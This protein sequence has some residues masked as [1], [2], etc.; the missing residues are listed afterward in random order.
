MIQKIDK[1]GNT[2]T[3][4]GRVIV[5]DKYANIKKVNKI[6]WG[7]ITGT[8]TDQTDL[9]TYLSTNYYPLTSNP[10]GYLTSSSLPISGTVNY[11]P[12]FTGTNSLGSS[13]ITENSV[14]QVI[15]NDSG[16]NVLSG[17]TKLSVQ[18]GQSQIDFVLGNPTLLQT[19]IV[20][21]DNTAGLDLIS[22][23]ELSLK[24]GSSNLEGIKLLTTGKLLF[25]Q[26][27]DTGTTSD[28]ILLRD[29][30]GNVKQISFPSIY[31][32]P[33]ASSSVL[34][35]VKIGSGVSIAGDGTISV[36]TN[37]Q[38]PLSGTGF[39]KISGTTIT[40]DNSSYY[41]SSNPSSFISLLNLS[42]GTGINYNNSTGVITSTITQYTD[43]QARL[44]LSSTA[45][46]LTYTNTTGVFSLSSGYLIPT[47]ASYNNTNWDIAFTQTLQWN[48]GSTNLVPVTGR[49]SLGATTVGSNLFTLA[50]PSAITFIRINADNSISTLDASTF[51]TAIGAGTS[52]NL[53]TVT[54]VAAITLGTTGT[55][56]S[57][58]VV[59]GTTTPIITLNVP[60]A[61]ATNRGALSSTDWS[62]FNGKQDKT[63]S[64]YSFRVNNTNA[65][66]NSTET[67][68]RQIGKTTYT[69]TATWTGTMAPSGTTNH[70]YNW[71]QIGNFVQGNLTLVYSVIGVSNTAVAITFPSDL[72]TPIKPDGLTLA[73]N[74]LYQITAKIEGSEATFATGGTDAY[75]RSN[76]T[77]T[78]FEFAITQVGIGAKIVR[79]SF[80]YFTV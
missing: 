65:T 73:L 12:K 38:A 54:S 47:I 14:G 78:G 20:W 71:I 58:S 51:R 29:T 18:R 21:S 34:G 64:A 68:F 61:S 46:G 15:I 74:G 1:Y 69:G 16:R 5:L 4:D 31:T 53:G 8:L 9:T 75:I 67:N 57:S 40:Y 33:I 56:L 27:P 36:S 13:F 28:Y 63:I 66:A 6:I 7:S 45:I 77:N 23:G 70:S 42:A 44:A 26:T 37:Y 72:P 59:T 79:I 80:Q 3:D 43:S 48:G 11:I 24:S 25:T 62:T 50:N 2:S 19:N 55:D 30:S 76:A 35:G 32:L 39:I 17:N 60:T 41:L 52:S 49:T 22:N 10:A